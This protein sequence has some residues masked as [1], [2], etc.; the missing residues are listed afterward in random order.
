MERKN[1]L[2]SNSGSRIAAGCIGSMVVGFSKSSA[3]EQAKQ[4]TLPMDP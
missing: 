4:L 2:T 1:A 3:C